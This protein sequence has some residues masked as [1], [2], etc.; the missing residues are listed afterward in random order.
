MGRYRSAAEQSG[1]NVSIAPLLRRRGDNID[2][3]ECEMEAASI[4]GDLEVITLLLQVRL[5]SNV[6]TRARGC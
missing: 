5:D 3:T 2:T 1:V 4:R 6:E